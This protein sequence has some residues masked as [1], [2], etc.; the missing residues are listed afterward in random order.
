MYGFF[1]VTAPIMALSGR[2][3]AAVG[4]DEQGNPV[5]K[6]PNPDLRIEQ[7]YIPFD[8]LGKLTCI[9]QFSSVASA[10]SLRKK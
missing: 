2:G 9:A 4:E 6:D 8:R 3:R 1:K 5:R 10:R 7:I